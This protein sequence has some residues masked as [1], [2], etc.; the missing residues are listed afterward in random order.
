MDL[1]LA[2]QVLLPT[3]RSIEQYRITEIIST[4][5]QTTYLGAMDEKGTPVSVKVPNR[6]CSQDQNLAARFAR[7]VE[8]LQKLSGPQFPQLRAHGSYAVTNVRDIPY[9]VTDMPRGPRMDLLIDEVRL[10]G[11]APDIALGLRILRSL[12]TAIG[13]AHEH[14]VV[15]R[16]LKPARISVDP[17][18]QV[19]ILDFVLGLDSG[20]GLLTGSGVL[21]G[22][23]QYIAPEQIVDAH[24][25]DGRADL[26]SIGVIIYEWFTASHPFGPAKGNARMQLMRKLTQEPRPPREANP[27]ISSSLEKLLVHLL[28]RDREARY[29]NTAAVLADL[30]RV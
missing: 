15:H 27:S 8:I 25:V 16:N 6:E 29:V 12:L 7:E 24:H 3:S 18:G 17:E 23:P 9:L 28:E 4:G 30:E 19:Q 20:S 26:Y 22:T 21:L 13:I 5:G 14:G 11:K 1:E 10:Q 2:R